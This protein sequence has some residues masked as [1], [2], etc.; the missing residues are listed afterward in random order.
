M[1]RVQLT[2]RFAAAAKPI[3]GEQTD[4]FD[5]T[6]KGLALRVG[7]RGKAWTYHYTS[8]RD[9]KRARVTLGSYPAASLVTARTRAIE[10]KG[11]VE[12]RRDPRDV[13]AAEAVGAMTLAGLIESYLAKHVRPNLR[14]AA[15]IER[16]L[17]KNVMPVIGAVRVA[18][19][20]R[21]DVNRVLDP[22]LARGRQVEAGR[23]FE[24]MRA[25]FRWALA[26][27]DLDHNPVEGMRK[28]NGSAPRERVLSDEEITTLWHGLPKTLRRSKA[29][30]RIIKLCL[31]TAQ[32][33]GEVAGMRRDELDLE[34]R[35][36]NLPGTRTKN[37]H[38]HTVPLSDLALVI[39]HEALI[40]AGDDAIFV[41]PAGDES[42]PP[43]AVARTIGRTQETSDNHP[44]GRFGIPRWTAHDLR[45]TA[46][47]NFARLGVAPVVA[48][49]VANHLSVT[50]ATITLSVYTRYTYDREKR[51]ALEL[52]ATRLEA[53]L[54]GKG[55]T[56]VPMRRQG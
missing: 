55:A 22:I 41:F 29:C 10:A 38:A 17:D 40:D 49:A 50:K 51:E 15:A 46:L 11:H 9:G 43:H 8:P 13:L 18:E 39:I 32:R 27:G 44:A 20:H 24:D 12:E 45:R 2:D 34:A 30:Q 36:W 16:R 21:R 53:V 37:G 3:D 6:I 7:P 26:R 52:W 47:T 28:P 1:P 19:L 25:M 5:A 23:V 48:G 14:S 56:V 33:V 35:T 54:A 31:V 4:Y 42:L